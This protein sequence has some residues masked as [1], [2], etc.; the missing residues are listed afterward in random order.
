M[1]TANLIA[2]QKLR[3]QGLSRANEAS[4]RLPA[5]R[6]GCHWPL[7]GRAVPAGRKYSTVYDVTGAG[8]YLAAPGPQAAQT[9]PG[10]PRPGCHDPK[11]GC[12]RASVRHN[13][14][15]QTCGLGGSGDGKAHCMG[16]RR[17][18]RRREQSVI[19]LPAWPGLVRSR[20]ARPRWMA[21]RGTRACRSS[22]AV[23]VG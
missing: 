1:Y 4:R 18:L 15:P 16:R 12:R 21:V 7:L 17:S 22:H 13:K 14:L 11:T 19:C 20:L 2:L 9:S 6:V 8:C 5:P 10:T 23:P 3:Q